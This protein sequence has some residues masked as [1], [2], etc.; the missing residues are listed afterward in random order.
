M[1]I[2]TSKIN[3]FDAMD[4][5]AKLKA[6][7]DYEI[8]TPQPDESIERLKELLSKANSEA[9]AN[10]RNAKE[11]A[12]NA[13]IKETEYE[14]QLAEMREQLAAI[15]A[16]KDLAD[17]ISDFTS[18]GFDSETAKAV[19]IARRDGNRAE[20]IKLFKAHQ[21]TQSKLTAEKLIG[22]TPRPSAAG[23]PKT[24]ASKDEILKIKDT[25]ERQAAI[26]NNLDLF[27]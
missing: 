22:G 14:K 24:Y 1:K 10:K 6:L 21:E 15:K 4:D 17:T 3:G 25:A 2:D 9:A 20:E 13:T 18:L 5:A 8:E 16:E 7:L 19:A 12:A 11:Q 26:A 27:K 23:T